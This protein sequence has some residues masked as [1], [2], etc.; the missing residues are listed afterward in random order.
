M[1]TELRT[2]ASVTRTMFKSSIYSRNPDGTT[3]HVVSVYKWHLQVSY[4]VEPNAWYECRTFS[5][6]TREAALEAAARM[7]IE[8]DFAPTHLPN[9]IDSWHLG[10]TSW[11]HA[12]LLHT[13]D[14]YE[15]GL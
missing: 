11:E 10:T 5:F 15:R 13:F 8:V 1:K 6:W 4:S 14:P 9:V 7:G 2:E 3:T 12:G